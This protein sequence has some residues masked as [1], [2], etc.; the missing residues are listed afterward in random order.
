MVKFLLLVIIFL[1]VYIIFFK[2]KSEKP[3]QNKSNNSNKNDLNELVACETCKIFVPISDTIQI[4]DKYHCS[5]TS[6][7]INNPKYFCSQKCA[8]QYFKKR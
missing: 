4:D 8:D 6:E 7:T 5:T 2:K 3:V 1:L